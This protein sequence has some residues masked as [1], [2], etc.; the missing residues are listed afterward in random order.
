MGKNELVSVC[1]QGAGFRHSAGLL[2]CSIAPVVA[3]LVPFIDSR[4][5][6]LC[7]RTLSLCVHVAGQVTRSAGVVVT[8]FLIKVPWSAGISVVS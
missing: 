6:V 2:W 7:S 3:L 1:L 4:H 8:R 5:P